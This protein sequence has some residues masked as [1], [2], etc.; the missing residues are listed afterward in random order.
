[1][2]H[3]N[4]IMKNAYKCKNT[5]YAVRVDLI[6]ELVPIQQQN[7]KIRSEIK[8][9]NPEAL[10]SAVIRNFK[11]VLLVKYRG[12]VQEFNPRMKFEDLQPG[13]RH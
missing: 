9:V 12:K 5:D 6:K 11:P 13:D 8:E 7:L 1:M 4:L 2:E 3:R 10:A